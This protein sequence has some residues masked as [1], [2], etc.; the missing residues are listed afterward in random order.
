[1]AEYHSKFAAKGTLPRTTPRFQKAKRSA[2]FVAGFALALLVGYALWRAT[3]GVP[4]HDQL[5]GLFIAD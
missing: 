2:T 3:L 5:P 4:Q 1:M